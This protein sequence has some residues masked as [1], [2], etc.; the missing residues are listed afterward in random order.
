MIVPQNT[1]GEIISNEIIS[2]D[3]CSLYLI[4]SYSFFIYLFLL[5]YIYLYCSYHMM[6]G[7][8]LFLALT[9]LLKTYPLLLFYLFCIFNLIDTSPYF[10]TFDYIVLKSEI[11]GERWSLPNR[12]SFPEIDIKFNVPW[13]CLFHSFFHS[14]ILFF[15]SFFLLSSFTHNTI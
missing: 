4:V 11:N 1:Q 7:K 9:N 13:W 15:L 8:E 5:C 2:W 6:G 3:V 12:S 10:I 14:F